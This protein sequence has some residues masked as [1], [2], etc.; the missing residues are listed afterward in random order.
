MVRLTTTQR[1]WKSTP[2]L[3][4][5]VLALLSERPD[6]LTVREIAESVGRA[7]GTTQHHLNVMYT[8]GLITRVPVQVQLPTPP[9]VYRIVS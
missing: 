3:R 9:Y 8:Q 4:E 1:P 7:T 5:K 2:I 6:G